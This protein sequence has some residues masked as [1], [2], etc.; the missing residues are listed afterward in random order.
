[1]KKL[2]VVPPTS[3][4]AVVFSVITVLGIV[5]LAQDKQDKTDLSHAPTSPAVKVDPDAT[6][7]WGPRTIPFPRFASQESRDAYMAL[8]NSAVNAGQPTDPKEYG[9]WAAKRVQALFAREKATALKLYPVDE[10]NR[11][12][13]G[14]EATIYTPK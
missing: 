2:R 3:L 1:M 11:K 7:H 12:V 6:V 8:V 5:A 10:E 4:L 9:P 13:G 14:V